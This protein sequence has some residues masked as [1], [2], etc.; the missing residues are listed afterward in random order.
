MRW[1]GDGH[2]LAIEP[3]D[4]SR[5]RPRHRFRLEGPTSGYWAARR[6]PAGMAAGTGA[7]TSE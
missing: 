2:S 6:E 4:E 7:A 3:P 5:G 1:E